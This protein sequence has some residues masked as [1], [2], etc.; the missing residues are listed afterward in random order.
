[1]ERERMDCPLPRNSPLKR[2]HE[3]TGRAGET[4]AGA[5]RTA[6]GRTIPEFTKDWLTSHI[7]TLTFPFHF[8]PILQLVTLYLTYSSI[9]HWEGMHVL[10]NLVNNN[11]T[12]RLRKWAQAYI[13]FSTQLIGAGYARTW[14][15]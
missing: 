5:S 11:K 9:D 4:A 14:P 8:T 12:A 10:Q 15:S 2:D 1:M 6:F 13:K 3:S 7:G